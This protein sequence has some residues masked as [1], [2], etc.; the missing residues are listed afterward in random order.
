M[1]RQYQSIIN[2]F[3]DNNFDLEVIISRSFSFFRKSL[4]VLSLLQSKGLAPSMNKMML[5]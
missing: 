2:P 1:P 4:M 5:A 3:F